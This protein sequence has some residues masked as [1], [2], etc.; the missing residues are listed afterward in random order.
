[1][2]VLQST[3]KICPN[4]RI[5]RLE[6]Y[7]VHLEVAEILQDAKNKRQKLL[8]Q[9]DVQIKMMKE[10]AQAEIEKMHQKAEA[11]IEQHRQQKQFEMMFEMLNKG[12]DFFSAME[13]TL[14]QTIKSLALKI[15]D[16]TPP[17]ERIYKL[18]KTTIKELGEGKMLHIYVHP[19]QCA[20]LKQNIKEIQKQVPTL[21]RIEV[22]ANKSMNLDECTLETETGILEAGLNL[23]LDNIMNAMKAM[24]HG[25]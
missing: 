15:F 11:E 9:A 7:A 8:E 10:A 14:V 24:L 12:I 20:L 13:D 23:Q 21:E 22:V 2:L 6:D 3:K 5:L 4:T 25:S 1:M 18:V 19:D 16:E 17:E